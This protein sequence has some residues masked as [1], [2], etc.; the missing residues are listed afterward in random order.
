MHRSLKRDYANQMQE[1]LLGPYF[2]SLLGLSLI[3][4]VGPT[5]RGNLRCRPSNMKTD[6]ATNS[7]STLILSAKPNDTKSYGRQTT[8]TTAERQCVCWIPQWLTCCLA[9]PTKSVDK[10]HSTEAAEA[11]GPVW[12]FIFP[13]IK[14]THPFRRWQSIYSTPVWKII[15]HVFNKYI[16]ST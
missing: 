7:F 1:L 8:F 11:P 16:L 15:Q 2:M 13:V 14:M 3:S 9:R 5:D 10:G 4:L 12:V 6:S